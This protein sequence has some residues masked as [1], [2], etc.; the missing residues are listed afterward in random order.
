MSG[1]CHPKVLQNETFFCAQDN[2]VFYLVS[3]VVVYSM[4]NN[5]ANEVCL[6]NF[7]MFSF[8]LAW[9]SPFFLLFSKVT[10][11][12]TDRDKIKY[13]HVHVLFENFLKFVCTNQF[14]FV[15]VNEFYKFNNTV[16]QEVLESFTVLISAMLGAFILMSL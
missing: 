5:D 4:F 16:T 3:F 10:R 8:F 1:W 7:V 11:F 6:I 2:G 12:T 13:V 15:F 9:L 14:S